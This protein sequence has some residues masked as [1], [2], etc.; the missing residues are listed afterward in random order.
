MLGSIRRESLARGHGLSL[1]SKERPRAAGRATRVPDTMSENDPDAA[2]DRAA[3]QCRSAKD[4]WTTPERQR[5]LA[6]SGAQYS[7]SQR[8]TRRAT[9]H[10]RHGRPPSR[11]STL[12][13]VA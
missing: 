13:L 7:L 8:L 2:I 3:S 12:L 4:L 11:P 10:Q 9:S 5:T 1:H 6:E